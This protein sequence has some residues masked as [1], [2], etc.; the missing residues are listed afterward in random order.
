MWAPR[1]MRT[2]IGDDNMGMQTTGDMK[3]MGYIY[4]INGHVVTADNM[5]GFAMREM[6]MVGNKSL[7]VK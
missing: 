6:V 3:K 4:S 5:T 2:F 1:Y 7:S